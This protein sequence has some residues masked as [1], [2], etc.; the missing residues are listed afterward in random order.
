[1]LS[2]LRVFSFL[3]LAALA[4]ALAVAPSRAAAWQSASSAAVPAPTTQSAAQTQAPKSEAEED[5]A[6]RHAPI[7]QTLARMMHLPLETT[8]RLFEAIN[9]L[10]IGLA[11]VIPLVRFL[12]KVVRKRSET[13]RHDIDAARKVTENANSRLSAV[14][15]RLSMLDQEIAKFRAEVEEGLKHDEARIQAAL[16]EERAHIVAAA[17]Q[18]IDVAAAHAR[19]GLRNFAAD[20]AIGKAAQQMTLSPEADRAL[21]AEFLAGVSDH[22][23]KNGGQN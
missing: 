18:E 1:M 13:L 19:R 22:G 11:I 7:V 17:E 6:Y 20:L 8:A 23:T 9:F 10:I 16:E 2:P 15:A 21:I 14:E 5:D 3:L 12:P 4:A